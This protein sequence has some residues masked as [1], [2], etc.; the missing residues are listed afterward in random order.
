MNRIPICVPSGTYPL[1]VSSGG[2]EDLG[3]VVAANGFV[4]G[5][6]FVVTNPIVGAL[7]LD[8]ACSSL[9]AAG[10]T[11]VP[12]EIPDGEVHKTID[13]WRALVDQLVDARIDRS[14]PVLALG[15]GV[16]GDI[17][18]FAAA[19]AMRGVPLIQV[20]TTLLAMVDS[21]V[22]GKTGVN[23]PRGKNLVGAF[24]QPELV[25]A[26]LGVLQTL[27]LEEVRAGMAEVVKHAVLGDPELWSILRTRGPDIVAGRDPDGLAQC[28]V[29][30]GVYKASV[31]ARD[32]REAG[33]RSLLNFGH[34]VGHAIEAVA[35][36]RLRHGTC[37]ALGMRAELRHGVSVGRT[38][39]WVAEE[40]DE[41]LMA[42]GLPLR[43]PSDL[44]RDGMVR[45]AAHD[46]KRVR[47]TV[48]VPVVSHIGTASCIAVSLAEVAEMVA[49][50]DTTVPPGELVRTVDVVENP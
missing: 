44:A 35:R 43:T 30:S 4:S 36:G 31:V 14:T 18:G 3:S 40:L 20:P 11:P 22:G 42:L 38:P 16:T 34:T 6:V 39:S 29:R 13:T 49:H 37:V 7:Y 1:I 21:S 5:R 19:T 50:L 10:L 23:T 15:G 32:E 46:K 33:V 24:H 17:A 28:V 8:T 26:P 41:V 9:S 47:G 27:A 48:R 25:F 12:I 2:V 45:A